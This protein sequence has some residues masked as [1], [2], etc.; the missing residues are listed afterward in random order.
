M[1]FI[2]KIP[3]LESEISKR[4]LL[5]LH[6]I[7][8]NVVTHQKKYVDILVDMLNRCYDSYSNDRK[9][10][11]KQD[12]DGMYNISDLTRTLYLEIKKKSMVINTNLLNLISKL[13]SNKLNEI[14]FK[15]EIC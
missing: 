15:W 3:Y 4:I 8:K 5:E 13:K 14:R 6:I 7:V 1:K 2:E 11:G 10:R 12:L 9:E